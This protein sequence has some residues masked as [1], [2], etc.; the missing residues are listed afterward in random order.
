M[1]PARPYRVDPSTG[2]GPVFTDTRILGALR[3]VLDNHD[4]L[5]FKRSGNYYVLISNGNEERDRH[6]RS[7]FDEAE[8]GI[9]ET[10]DGALRYALGA[11]YE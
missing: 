2:L 10:L 7:A 6:V 4:V 1:P 8:F 3:R 5:M 9:W 11:H